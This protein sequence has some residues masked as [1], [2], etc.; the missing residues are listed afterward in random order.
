MTKIYLISPPQID[1][2][3]IFLQELDEL[4][5]LK[6][7]P[8]FQLRLKDYPY[9]FIKK[10][11]ISCKNIC[12]KYNVKF[13]IND[14]ANLAI[15]IGASGVHVG[16]DDENIKIIRNRV[17]SNFIIGASCYD[18]RDLALK[19]VGDGANYISFG[20]FF[21]SPTKK[22]RGKPQPEII[23]KNKDLNV[24]IVAIGGINDSNCEIL[25]NYDIDYIAIISYIWS[26]QNKLCDLQNI[27]EKIAI[28]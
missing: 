6:I 14:D 23:A 1:D 5:S 11:A 22:S 28:S 7:V 24:E 8:I 20:A 18:S 13:I 12:D 2:L 9:D 26:S 17:D 27:Y 10:A 4:L 21:D 15:E 3:E 25:I 19:A 16:V